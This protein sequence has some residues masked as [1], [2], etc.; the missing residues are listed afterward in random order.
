MTVAASDVQVGA[1]GCSFEAVQGDWPVEVG[2]CSILSEG[3][4]RRVSSA[5]KHV[6]SVKGKSWT[7]LGSEVLRALLER[8]DQRRRPA[9]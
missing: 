7:R 2:N 5:G 1:M 6:A 4:I 9:V 8:Y 3:Q